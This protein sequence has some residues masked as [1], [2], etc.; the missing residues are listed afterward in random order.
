MKDQFVQYVNLFHLRFIY[1]Q[2]SNTDFMAK[3]IKKVNNELSRIWKEVITPTFAFW[4]LRKT[5]IN[6]SQDSEYPSRDSK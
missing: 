5:K 1:P 2:L 6:L 3:K 4:G